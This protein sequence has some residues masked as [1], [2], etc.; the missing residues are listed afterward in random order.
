MMT[1]GLAL[2]MPPRVVHPAPGIEMHFGPQ[3]CL[4]VRTDEAADGGWTHRADA[5]AEGIQHCGVG[6]NEY[7]A[8]YALKQSAGEDAVL[9]PPR[10]GVGY[11]SV[12]P[13]S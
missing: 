2:M 3:Y 11:G 5:M 9:I 4:T 8:V 6:R 13:C 1:S 7:E 10:P 12:K